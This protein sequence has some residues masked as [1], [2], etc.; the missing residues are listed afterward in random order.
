MRLLLIDDDDLSRE[1][2]DLVL[3]GDG[4]HL[5]SFA[6]GDAALAHLRS[7]APPP[8]A[9]LTDLQM[10]GLQGAPL[11]RALRAL[12]PP[13][14]PILVMSG[15]TPS[16]AALAPFDGFLLKPFTA[17]DLRAALAP[18]SS[19]VDLAAAAE[20]GNAE[21]EPRDG[22]LD[23]TAA[24]KDDLVLDDRIHHELVALMRPPQL[25]ELFTLCFTEM[26]RHTV[27]MHRARAAGDPAAFRAAAHAL[28]G[29]TGMV[30]AR[31]LHALADALETGDP[32]SVHHLA[33]LREIP[34]AAE[35]LQRILLSRGID[36]AP[37]PFPVH[38]PQE[39]SSHE[40]GTSS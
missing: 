34:L 30:G 7:G 38:E 18:A 10:P 37:G 28:K 36:L 24:R 6:S 25:H 14:T 2:L 19:I 23:D 11:A 9:V 27:A 1:V 17:E 4:F 5:T 29:A 15:S 35:R 8:D 33:S 22:A 12:C 13:A 16:S 31:E 21:T 40:P 26:A 3:T 39:T 32:T 20:D